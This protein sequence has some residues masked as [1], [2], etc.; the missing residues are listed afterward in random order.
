MPG[1]VL[2][3]RFKRQADLVAERDVG[4]MEMGL[5]DRFEDEV[6]RV[7]EGDM[8]LAFFHG[9][10][11]ELVVLAIPEQTG[12]GG[13]VLQGEL[14]GRPRRSL[15]ASLW[16]RWLHFG[17]QINV[18]NPTNEA[19]WIGVVRVAEHRSGEML[20]GETR[21]VRAIAGVATGVIHGWQ[22]LVFP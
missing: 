4:Q 15:A 8:E 16:R 6:L 9:G 22:S 14:H 19:R 18:S 3:N 12:K 13:D 1:L 11:N 7:A 20:L 5:T 17:C 10:L 2:R 21:H